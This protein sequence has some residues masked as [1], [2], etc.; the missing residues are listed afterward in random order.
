MEKD[1]HNITLYWIVIV[2]NTTFEK[3]K[4]QNL[5]PFAGFLL[6]YK[7]ISFSIV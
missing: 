2:Y 3:K 7:V 4:K 6:I 5:L 1:T